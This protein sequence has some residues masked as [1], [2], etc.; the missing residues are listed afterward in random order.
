MPFYKKLDK[1]AILLYLLGMIEIIQNISIFVT[2]GAIVI[3]IILWV[4]GLRAER[5]FRFIR[6]EDAKKIE[7]LARERE[8][9]RN[10]V[11]KKLDM[12]SKREEEQQNVLLDILK[13][14]EDR[15]DQEREDLTNWLD[16]KATRWQN[17]IEDRFSER[18]GRLQQDIEELKSRLDRL[19]KKNES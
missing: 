7:A 16:Y 12:L 13:R 15:S 19:E 11:I 6:D 3:I 2:I 17:E 1:Q 18:I 14:R 8:E 10:E 5:R 9:L 4:R